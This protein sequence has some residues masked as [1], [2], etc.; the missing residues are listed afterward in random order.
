MKAVWIALLAAGVSLLTMFVAIYAAR[1]K[2]REREEQDIPPAGAPAYST[3]C[4]SDGGGGC[5]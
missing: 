2:A 5:D 3:D 1:I 4:S